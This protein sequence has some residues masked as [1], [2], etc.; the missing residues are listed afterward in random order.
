M[1]QVCR[2]LA[3]KLIIYLQKY[4]FQEQDILIFY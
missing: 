2:C 3:Y 1:L 4:A